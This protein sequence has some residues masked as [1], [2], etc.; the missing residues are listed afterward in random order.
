ML[1]VT[2][3]LV[4]H[5]IEDRKET[6]A[7]MEIA[8]DGTG[9]RRTG[10]YNTR[11]IDKNGRIHRTGRVEEHPRLDLSVWKLIIKALSGLGH[12]AG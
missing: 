3:E 7:T 2:V 6:L 11:L 10:N 8:N 1:R 9:T 12:V 4:P 5:G